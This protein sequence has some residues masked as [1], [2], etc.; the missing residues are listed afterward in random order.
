MGIRFSLA[1]PLGL[2]ALR[3]SLARGVRTEILLLIAV[4]RRGI[5]DTERGAAVMSPPF[6][7]G[8]Q[9]GGFVMEEVC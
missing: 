8:E 3:G 1:I 2:E 7:Q 4:W 6:L 9:E 5:A